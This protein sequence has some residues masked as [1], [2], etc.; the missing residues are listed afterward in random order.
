MG[1]SGFYARNLD[2]PPEK[3]AASF[4]GMP[5]EVAGDLLEYRAQIDDLGNVTYGEIHP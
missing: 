2:W 3:L 5:V 1:T 4:R